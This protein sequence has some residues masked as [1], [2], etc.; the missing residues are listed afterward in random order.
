MSSGGN[1]AVPS[2]G[3]H[4][5]FKERPFS[6][7]PA[8]WEP[9]KPKCIEAITELHCA[10]NLKFCI[11]TPTTIMINNLISCILKSINND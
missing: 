7:F 11:N 3:G 10:N 4:N 1:G 9:V 6:S 5:F 8:G 2:G